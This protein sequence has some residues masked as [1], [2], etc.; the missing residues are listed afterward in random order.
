MRAIS[1]LVKPVSGNCNLTCSYCF[2]TGHRQAS[3]SLSTFETLITK[4]VQYADSSIA[5]C[6]QGG[7]PTLAGLPFYREAVAIIARY[8]LARLPV[9]LSLQTNGLRLDHEWA[10]F[11]RENRV[12]VGLS[13]DGPQPVH[14]STRQDAQG[15]GTFSRV[16]SA[17]KLLQD[18]QVDFNIL[19]VVNRQVA[20]NAAEVYWFF[21]Q[22]GFRY[23]QFIP[24]LDP[25][26]AD[27]TGMP[28]LSAADYSLFLKQTFELW[29][30]DLVAGNYIS[31]RQ[32]DSY[33]RML[34]GQEPDTCGMSGVCAAY[35]LVESQGQVYPCDFYAT[36]ADE[37]GNILTDD[38]RQIA[39]S[40]AARQFIRDSLAIDERC[41]VCQW[42]TLCRGG[43]K[44]NRT[45]GMNRYCSVY[46]EFFAWAMP[47][48]VTIPL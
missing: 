27:G 18:N 32:F 34:H 10:D 6:F 16:M 40:Q 13:L 24:C 21:R 30:D 8:N 26:S 48:L 38:F 35:F 36:P 47:R 5:I 31:I 20:Y 3:M 37:L 45:Q 4:A 22:Q 41:T 43:C 15:Q 14:D 28:E 23:L 44:R 39:S 17:V 42:R 9:Q 1:L 19:S 12:L 46:R 7:E 25:P 33:V 29:Y 2:Y 11:L